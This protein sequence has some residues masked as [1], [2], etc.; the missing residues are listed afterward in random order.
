[1]IGIPDCKVLGGST[2]QRTKQIAERLERCQ[3]ENACLRLKTFNYGSFFEPLGMSEEVPSYLRHN[4]PVQNL[5]WSSSQLEE[6]VSEMWGEKVEKYGEETMLEYFEAY[7]KKNF[8]SENK[9]AEFIYN[10]YNGLWIYGPS[11]PR[12]ALFLDVLDGLADETVLVSCDAVAE[13]VAAAS[14]DRRDAN[15]RD[16]LALDDVLGAL[17]A[18]CTVKSEEDISLL[19]HIL[20]GDVEQLGGWDDL[21]PNH[22]A[23]SERHKLNFT[24]A[25]QSQ[26]LG[27]RRAFI[28]DITS[29]LESQLFDENPPLTATKV[30]L[31]PRSQTAWFGNKGD[32]DQKKDKKKLFKW[33]W[34]VV[35]LTKEQFQKAYE[36]ADPSAPAINLERHSKG[37]FGEEGFVSSLSETIGFLLRVP[38]FR[39]SARAGRS[40]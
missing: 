3:R 33:N 15:G 7:L 2:E 24:T 23:G 9:R 13:R 36:T 31:E 40:K 20:K 28:T 4:K 27:E 30:P 6:T 34:E 38:L 26:S 14:A 16:A 12:V 1:M 32:T 22:L 18:V 37:L 29:S 25:L 8:M 35:Q 39:H 19:G 11:A 10:F 21:T 5:H 17:R